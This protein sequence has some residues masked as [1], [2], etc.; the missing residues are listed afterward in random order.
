M[1]KKQVPRSMFADVTMV[2]RIKHADI[3]IE[4]EE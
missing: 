1:G 3:R 4:Y 2:R